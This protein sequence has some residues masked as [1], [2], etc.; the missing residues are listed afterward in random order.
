MVI[1]RMRKAALVLAFLL[2]AA[3]ASAQDYKIDVLYAK[4][5]PL[6]ESYAKQMEHGFNLG[7][8]YLTNGTILIDGHKV[9]VLF[10]DTQGKPDMA[11]A[12]LM[13]AYKDD[14]ADLVLSLI[15]ISEPTRRT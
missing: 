2:G 10:K 12:L 8:E 14:K 15:H 13:E 7:M 11:K 9:T 3:A 5:H 4:S 6:F 1:R